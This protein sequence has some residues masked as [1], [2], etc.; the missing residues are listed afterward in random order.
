MHLVEG[1]SFAG[2]QNRA[3]SCPAFAMNFRAN[4]SWPFC[5]QTEAGK[6][7]IMHPQAIEQPSSTHG[8]IDRRKGDN[9]QGSSSFERR[10]F[11]DGSRS[12]RPEVN[13]LASAVD[14]YKIANRRRFITFEELYDVMASLGYH[15]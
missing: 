12:N 7:N 9:G 13:E 2:L 8:F 4:V 6:I 3:N 1:K 15:K 11:Q 14:D 5:E 10:Q